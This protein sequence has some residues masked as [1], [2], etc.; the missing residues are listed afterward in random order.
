MATVAV[1]IPCRNAARWVPEAVQSCLDQE[2][3]VEI[4]A[5]DDGSTDDTRAVLK[6]FGPPVTVLRG[7]GRGAPAARN[8]AFAASTAPFI[9]YLDAD[10]VILPGKLK[11]QVA[12]LEENQA[13]IVYGDWRYW[14]DDGTE[15]RLDRIQISGAQVDPMEALLDDWWIPLMAPL[16]RRTAVVAAGGWD[17]D[18]KIGQDHD[19]LLAELRGGARMAYQPGC[20]SLYRQGHSDQ[21]I[22]RT[23]PLSWLSGR[24]T[25][26]E[27]SHAALLEDGALTP[28]RRR[29][30]ARSYQRLARW[31]W[32]HDPVEAARLHRLAQLTDPAARRD[33]ELPYRMMVG[34]AGFEGAERVAQRRRRLLRSLGRSVQEELHPKPGR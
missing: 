5:V 24:S 10:D 7:S 27:K 31:W 30:L 28:A 14:F 19:F 34:L 3:D 1:L 21:T 12:F 8:L 13:E 25:L 23:D 33:L 17:L 15:E 16:H 4:I 6:R 11:C 32:E 2:V 26:L 20:H 9:Q 18:I 22:S 29:A